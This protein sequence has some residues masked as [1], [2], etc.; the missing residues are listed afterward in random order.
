MLRGAEPGYEDL[1]G[2]ERLMTVRAVLA[3]LLLWMLS[4]WDGT[5]L[6]SRFP[7]EQR[8]AEDSN[9]RK[10]SIDS[11]RVTRPGPDGPAVRYVV[12]IGLFCFRFGSEEVTPMAATP[13]PAEAVEGFS[14][15]V[16]DVTGKR[17]VLL[18]QG[19][20]ALGSYQV[21]AFEALQA[22]L[23]AFG[24]KVDWVVGISIGAINAAVI[25]G[26]KAEDLRPHYRPED[27]LPLG[28]G[29]PQRPTATVDRPSKL[30]LL[31]NDILWPPFDWLSPWAREYDSWLKAWSAL[32]PWSPLSP[33]VGR[34][35]GWNMAAWGGQRNFFRSRLLVPFLNPW[36]TEFWDAP[37]PA[38]E[39][40]NYDT[41]PLFK[42]LTDPEKRYVDWDLINSGDGVRLSLGATEVKNG[43]VEFFNS[44]E[45]KN[46]FALGQQKAI[47]AQHVMASGALPPAF[48]PVCIEGKY[49]WDGGLSS[50]TPLQVLRD[51][52]FA[53]PQSTVVFDILVW[54]RQGRVPKTMDEMMWRQKS[55][56]FGSRKKIAE[57]I[58]DDYDH[59]ADDWDRRAT[60]RNMSQP[61]SLTVCQVMYE[62][63][64][65]DSMDPLDS[66]FAYSDAEFSISTFNKRRDLGRNDMRNAIYRATHVENVG[67]AHGVL[68]RYGTHHKHL[69]TDRK[70]ARAASVRAFA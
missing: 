5:C 38:S 39:V 51:E 9:P 41:E 13:K 59:K 61:P 2:A 68:Y 64:P 57:L 43:E 48:P 29:N 62:S 45:P 44:F 4:R 60:S 34:Y 19:G 32:V 36:L 6:R 24:R 10:W 58:V 15:P 56:Q 46:Q 7:L 67:G 66:E 3:L 23:E 18:L 35:I 20:G 50:N 22:H 14:P 16:I 17:I 28:N 1:A 37:F 70:V 53:D 49:Y 52:L 55:I 33:L 42:L 30:E 26:N 12:R 25:A 54:D 47:Q 11:C 8:N 31:W 63:E 40:A 21:G 69:E 27:L 65:A